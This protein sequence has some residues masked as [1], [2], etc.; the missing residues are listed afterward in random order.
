[1]SSIQDTNQ[2]FE[3]FTSSM[4]DGMM[5]EGGLGNEITDQEIDA[6]IA[7]GT[8]SHR[9]NEGAGR[10]EGIRARQERVT[11]DLSDLRSRLN[12]L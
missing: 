10:P 12:N 5:L 1:M 4:V 8:G 11:D 9:G 2:Q 6:M 3:V 7:A